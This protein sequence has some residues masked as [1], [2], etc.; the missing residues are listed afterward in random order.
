MKR[1]RPPSN[2]FQEHAMLLIAHVS[3]SNQRRANESMV[4]PLI[5]EAHDRPYNIIFLKQRTPACCGPRCAA[6]E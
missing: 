5:P 6:R 4:R 3:S 1:N 2:S